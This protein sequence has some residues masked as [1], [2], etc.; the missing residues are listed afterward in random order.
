MKFYERL[1][2]ARRKANITQ[3]QLAKECNVSQGTIANW[4]SGYRTPDLDMLKKIASLLD[5]SYDDLLGDKIVEAVFDGKITPDHVKNAVKEKAPDI[6]RSD[7][8]AIMSQMDESEIDQMI[9]YAQ[10]L[11]SKK[12]IRF[13]PEDQSNK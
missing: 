4:E 10:Y 2:E 13:V 7:L 1:R 8:E 9:D 11:L 3:V 12:A 6:S 5:V